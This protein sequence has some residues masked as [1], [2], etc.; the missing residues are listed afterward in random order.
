MSNGNV[1]GS[2]DL[3][4]MRTPRAA[5]LGLLVCGV[6]STSA[7]ERG[8]P[9]ITVYPAEVHKGGPQTFDIAQDSRGVLY[10]GN[11]HGLVTYDGAWWR[12]LKL[13]DDQVALS[14][15]ADSRGR[16]AMGLVNDFGYLEHDASGAERYHSLLP[17][18]PE[19]SREVRDVRSICSTPAGFPFVT[20]RSVIL[21][22]GAMTRVVAQ[23]ADA[24]A[25]RRCLADGGDVFLYG[26]TGLRRFDSA[27]QQIG[28]AMYSG[29]VA[30][31][32][33]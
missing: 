12:L 10:F 32:V 27:T 22:N 15:A 29:S 25:P 14:L 21:W 31:A 16:V 5:V 7:A 11:L 30:A 28:P 19:A 2:T 24:N 4:N 3:R 8:F 1:D 26:P 23:F 9:L 18:I 6:L 13:P 33:R 20:E 17:T